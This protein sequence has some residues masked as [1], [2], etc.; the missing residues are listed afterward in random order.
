MLPLLWGK[1]SPWFSGVTFS[2]PE[3]IC[4]PRPIQDH[5]PILIGGSG[6]KRT[7]R[8]VAQY[9]DACNLFG[10]PEVIRRKVDVLHRHCA[11]IDR[12][13]DQIEVSH[14][15]DVMTA[16]DRNSLRER[17]DQLRGRNMTAEAY[18]AR[19]NAGIVGDHLDHIAGYRA[20]GASH[21][22]VA[23]PDVHLD[24]SIEAFGEVIAAMPRP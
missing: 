23:M 11:E 21:S 13:P 8:L 17:V 15:V 24:G 5:I 12:N 18:M 10:R 7:L 20:A 1:G 19:H 16:M 4:Y 2:A 6:E 9:A 3:L 14:L 22:I